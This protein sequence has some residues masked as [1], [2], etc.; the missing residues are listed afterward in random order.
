MLAR[1]KEK[2]KDPKVSFQQ[3]DI[4]KEWRFPPNEFDLVTFSLILEHVENLMDVFEKVARVS[5]PGG[6]VYVA[7]LHPFKQYTGTKARF[8]TGHGVQTV[9]C[10]NHNISDFTGAAKRNGFRII[11]IEEYFD[12]NNRSNIPRIMIILFKKEGAQ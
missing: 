8:E 9:E 12:D 1:A 10:F 3:A 6:Y 11:E 7:E 4:R 5:Q 2:I